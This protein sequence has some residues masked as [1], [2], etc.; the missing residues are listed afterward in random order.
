MFRRKFDFCA[1]QKPGSSLIHQAIPR[2]PAVPSEK[3][4][5]LIPFESTKFVTSATGAALGRQQNLTFRNP[6]LHLFASRFSVVFSR[7]L[8]LLKQE[9]ER[10]RSPTSPKPPK[11]SEKVQEPHILWRFFSESPPLSFAKPPPV[12]QNIFF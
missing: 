4:L 7:G 11:Q 1:C 2:Y 8:H 12:L 9:K 10:D 3:V 6:G 5:D